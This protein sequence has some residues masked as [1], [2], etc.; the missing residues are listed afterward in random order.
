[1]K[2]RTTATNSPERREVGPHDHLLLVS[3]CYRGPGNVYQELINLLAKTVASTPGLIWKT[4]FINEAGAEAGSLHLFY[5]R[6]ALERYLRGRELAAL[7]R[8]EGVVDLTVKSFATL[9]E[10]PLIAIKRW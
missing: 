9:N 7:K 5:D 2:T 4:W 3:F 6:V 10:I 8:E 1:M